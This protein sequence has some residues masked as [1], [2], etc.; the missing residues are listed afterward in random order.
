MGKFIDITGRTFGRLT[1][2]RRVANSSLGQTRWHC[3]CQCGGNGIFTSYGLTRG[4]S[5]SCGCWKSEK[6]SQARTKHGYHKRNVP[7]MPEYNIWKCIRQ[8][9]LNPKNSNFHNYGGRGVAICERWDSFENF[10]ADM[11]LRPTIISTIERR[12]VNGPYSPENCIWLRKGL[13]SRNTRRNRL[14]TLNG[15]TK[16]LCEWAEETNI[17]YV[18]ILMRLKAGWSIEDALT[19]SPVIGRNRH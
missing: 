3:E 10:F 15:Q 13:Q 14:L 1:V 7:I 11:G 8:R 6:I 2:V 17:G 9:C 5:T 16:L 12:D 18:T 19:L 4:E